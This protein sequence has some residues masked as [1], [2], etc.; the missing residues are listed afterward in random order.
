M[1]VVEDKS[2]AQ[3]KDVI[4]ATLRELSTLSQTSQGNRRAHLFQKLVTAIR[5]LKSD[6][7]SPAVPEMVEVSGFLTWQALAQCGTPECSSAI[8]QILRTMDKTAVEVDAAVYA[9]ALL[10]NPTNHL[11]QDMLRM[12]EYKPSKPILYGLSNIVRR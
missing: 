11:V 2:P 1:E 6:T 10:P 8:L 12:A 7:L 9:M 4:L 5:G 3:T